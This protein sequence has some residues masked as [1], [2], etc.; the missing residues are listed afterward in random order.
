MIKDKL[1]NA[2]TY[3][4]LSN[5]LKD[6]LIWLENTDLV[7]ELIRFPEVLVIDD[8]GQQL[9]VKS[10]DEALRIAELKNLDLLC[11]A[12]MAKPPVCKIMNYGKYKFEQQKK[13][14]EMKKNQKV[15]ETKEVRLTPQTDIGDLKTKA[16]AVEKWIKDGNKVK[17]TM[18]YRGRQLSHVDVG[19]DTL[20]KFLEL[21]SEFTIVEKKPVL[22]GKFLMC[23][24]APKPSK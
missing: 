7:N 15:V 3:Y 10:R 4:N 17:V 14:K 13:L 2:K 11:V 5:N 9:G 8:K 22:E 6:G 19:E 23:F 24:I 16:R 21:V 18:R 20:D 1:I 12:P